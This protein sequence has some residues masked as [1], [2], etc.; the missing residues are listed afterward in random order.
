MGRIFMTLSRKITLVFITLITMILIISGLAISYLIMNNNNNTEIA[1]A[2]EIV[3]AYDDA[4]FQ[5]VRANAA[6][7][8]YMMFKEQFMYDN[9]YDIR[10][11]LHETIDTLEQ[12]GEANDDFKQYV[13]QLD[14]WEKAID[15]DILP[16]IEAGAAH[17]ELQETSNPI[18]G[19][20]SMLLV[21]FSK[22]MAN[23]HN[24]K[25][26]TEFDDLLAKNKMMIWI[27]VAVG[28]VS[29]LISLILTLT[30]GRHLRFSITQVIQK[31]NEFATGNFNVT[32]HLKSKDE[33][34]ELS[35]SFNEMTNNLRE[36][37]KEVGGAALQVATKAEQFSA[38]SEEV[39][40]A[41]A[42][43]TRSIV[44]I[45]DG[46]E[47]QNMM[48]NEVR[49]LATENLTNVKGT[50]DNIKEM[51]ERVEYADEKSSEGFAEVLQVSEQMATILA[52]SETITAE[53]NELNEQ[54]KTI[55]DSIGSIK[56]I[57]EQT[58]LLALNAS[59]EAARAGESG[60]GF[61]V[62]ANE[63]RNLAEASN[64][65]SVMIEEVIQSISEKMDNT[66]TIISN[67]NESVQEGQE[68]VEANGK[69]FAEITEAVSAVKSGANYMHD[70]IAT[71]FSNIE[72][73]VSRIEQTQDISE[74]TS[75]ESQN[76]AATA[77]EQSATMVEVADASSELADL[78]IGLQEI[79]EKYK[80]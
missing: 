65:T 22:G 60:Q 63:V 24:E 25:I 4:A 37:M 72:E 42:G 73:L 62:V 66:V 77:E 38:S 9:H 8:G 16:L 7:R 15:N 39:S 71:V 19:E 18:L 56:G 80:Y 32:L 54:I 53:I 20:G 64:S 74:A 10:E 3:L 35:T 14:D 78:A 48:T 43:I 27:I 75:D 57:A 46:M 5:T 68:R 59:I 47:N 11:T 6:I 31:L 61:A 2:K 58:N 41:T 13:Q 69:M 36:T 30:F 40:S 79:I 12:L 45:S 17:E 55:T 52:N 23:E 49:N 76:I 70:A 1:R 33:F 44:N 67:N 34:G 51:V 29:L 28:G 50:L 26:I 21:T